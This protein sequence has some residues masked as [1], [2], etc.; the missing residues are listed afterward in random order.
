MTF[1]ITSISMDYDP[2]NE[3]LRSKRSG[4]VVHLILRWRLMQLG[5]YSA[6][7]CLR[8]ANYSPASLQTR[9]KDMRDAPTEYHDGLTALGQAAGWLVVSSDVSSDNRE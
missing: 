2:R 7:Q 6:E 8:P 3:L 4:E 1:G 9:L 5:R